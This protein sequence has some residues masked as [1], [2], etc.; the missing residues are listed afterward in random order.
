MNKLD[1]K[2]VIVV[3]GEHDATRLKQF[4]NVETIITNGS[5]I[6]KKTLQLIKDVND[7]KGII[8]FC[9][10]DFPGEKIRQTIIDYVGECKHAFIK[11][12]KAIDHIKKKVGIEHASYEDL[13]QSLQSCVSFKEDDVLDWNDFI[14][15]DLVGNKQLRQKVC[16]YLNI[17]ICNSK[18]L[19]KRLNMLLIDYDKLQKIIKDVK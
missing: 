10:P 11:K 17:S 16:D 14:K 18:T 7:T 12:D 2:E 19:Y 15:C 5:A 8:V 13:L 4:F 9:D 6:N 3:E 1:I